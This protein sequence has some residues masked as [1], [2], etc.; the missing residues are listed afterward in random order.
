MDAHQQ[1]WHQYYSTAAPSTGYGPL[2][3]AVRHHYQHPYHIPAAHTAKHNTAS[4]P[5]RTTSPTPC[6]DPANP[7][8]AGLHAPQYTQHSRHLDTK[9]HTPRYKHST[10]TDTISHHTT[11]SVVQKIQPCRT[12]CPRHLSMAAQPLW[13]TRPQS[14]HAISGTL[15]L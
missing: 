4:I 6:H 13:S 3:N 10:R 5:T 1:W 8:T 12:T 9:R 14:P 7:T 11:N 15:P 2:T